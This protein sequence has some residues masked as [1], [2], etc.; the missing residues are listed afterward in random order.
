MDW[1]VGRVLTALQEVSTLQAVQVVFLGT[2]RTGECHWTGICGSLAA[3][4]A[5]RSP[6]LDCTFVDENVACLHLLTIAWRLILMGW[7][8]ICK[9]I[10]AFLEPN[11]QSLSQRTQNGLRSSQGQ[12]SGE[13]SE[14]LAA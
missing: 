13:H 10:E 14:G 12:T 7:Q 1:L 11:A 4:I 8:E 3:N 5:G 6:V 2:G 9:G